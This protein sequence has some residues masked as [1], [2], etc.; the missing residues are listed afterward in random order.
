MDVEVA[1]HRLAVV[2]ARPCGIARLQKTRF[3]TAGETRFLEQVADD[4]GTLRPDVRHGRLLLRT[5]PCSQCAADRPGLRRAP[6]VSS[7]HR[8]TAAS[9]RRTPWPPAG[10]AVSSSP[11]PPLLRS[12]PAPRSPSRPDRGAS[13]RAAT[14]AR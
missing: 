3:G 9:G 13:A 6:R 8:S 4:L 12:F 11:P 7:R 14:P 1:L 5:A 10:I 2:D